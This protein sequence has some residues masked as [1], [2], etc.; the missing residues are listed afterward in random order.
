MKIMKKQIAI[1]AVM[2]MSL[3]LMSMERD[4]SLEEKGTRAMS[5]IVDAI[6]NNHF[7]YKYDLN[8]K[9]DFFA[10]FIHDIK[11]LSCVNKL[12]DAVLK[13]EDM[14]KQIIRSVAEKMKNCVNRN[15]YYCAHKLGEYACYYKEIA[16]YIETA[17]DPESEIRDTW[18]ANAT[19]WISEQRGANNYCWSYGL[20]IMTPLR[21]AIHKADYKWAKN[22]IAQGADVHKECI[23]D[24]G[25]Y[26][27]ISLVIEEHVSHRNWVVYYDAAVRKKYGNST[28]PLLR[29]LT[30]DTAYACEKYQEA[31]E[32]YHTVLVLLLENKARFDVPHIWMRRDG[33]HQT[34]PFEHAIKYKDEKSVLLLQQSGA[35]ITDPD[36]LTGEDLTWFNQLVESHKGK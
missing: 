7:T 10:G 27:L 17:F 12:F 15:D 9:D 35:V 6:A 13:A 32:G 26:P 31:K 11:A 16:H 20:R 30:K 21:L 14:R 22:L 2:S 23:N 25:Q 5:F 29:S 3:S 18:Y 34:F 19:Q 33:P 36:Y 24:N 8:N 1:V 4:L 28:S